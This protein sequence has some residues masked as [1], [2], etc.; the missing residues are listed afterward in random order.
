MSALLGRPVL[1]KNIRKQASNPGLQKQHLASLETLSRIC[2]AETAGA[3]LHSMQV[4]FSPKQVSNAR[5]AVNIGTAGSITLFLQSLLLSSMLKEIKL[6][7]IGGTDV[8]MAPSY[9]YFREVLFPVLQK[10][11]AR[12]D[13][14]LVQH[15]FFPKGKGKVFF[16][17]TQAKFQLKPVFLLELGGLEHIKLYSQ[18]SD[19]PREV[20][21][22][23]AIAARKEL[24]YLGVEIIEE[25]YS[26][27]P[28]STIGSSI[29]LIAFFNSG[30]IIGVNALGARGKPAVG[31]GREAAKKLLEEISRG[32]PVDQ[33][34]ADQLVPFMALAKGK[35]TICTTKL[36]EHCLSSIAVTEKFLNTKFEVRGSLNETAEISVEGIGWQP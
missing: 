10:M 11:G 36:T 2:N 8:P 7:I 31:V 26:K 3:R 23:Q 32:K 15:G 14:N 20:S 35:S 12:F 27:Q 4:E 9:Y 17:S 18:S 5:L 24:E 28:S 21:V 13:C 22:N 30:A 6:S 33:H 34:L 25:I 19:L 1:V 29:D 16:S